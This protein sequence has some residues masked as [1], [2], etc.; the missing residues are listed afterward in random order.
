[1]QLRLFNV[2]V[3]HPELR[4]YQEF[5][6]NELRT[7]ISEGFRKFCLVLPTGGGKTVIA[8]KIIELARSLGK[9]VL[10]VAHRVELINQAGRQLERFGVVDIGIIRGEDKRTNEDAPVQ[11]ASI[12]TLRNRDYPPADIVFI[13]EC[14][15]ALSDSYRPLFNHYS[16]SLH[17]GLTA[18]PFRTDSQGLG[19]VYQKIIVCAKPSQ[20]IEDKFIMAPRIFVAPEWP[21]LSDVE[22]SGG[23]FDFH[24]NHLAKAMSKPKLLGN[25]VEEWKKHA[26]NRRTVCFAVNVE[27]SKAIVEA[28]REAGVNAVHIDGN[29]PDKERIRVL[30]ELEAMKIQLVS[31]CDVL[32][33]GWDQPSVRCAIIARPTQSLRLHLQQCGRILRWYDGDVASPE[34]TPLLIDHAGNCLRHGLPQQDREFDLVVGQHKRK[35]SVPVLHTCKQC[36]AIWMGSRKCPECGVELQAKEQDE[37]IVDETV[38]LRELREPTI[39]T[40]ADAQRAFFLKELTK[41]RDIGKR[42]GAAGYAYKEK[43][44]KWPPYSWSTQA[45][46]FYAASPDWQK[47]VEDRQKTREFWQQRKSDAESS[48][49]KYP[50]HNEEESPGNHFEDYGY[51]EIPDDDIPF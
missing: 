44:G 33:E 13:D 27:H 37:I 4:P 42:P 46:E 28:F 30:L 1:M 21:D 19:E 16:D 17:I 45:K 51:T 3:V 20:L 40:E 22:V 6:I 34:A 43:F 18:T 15:R 14:H 24:N 10:F 39:L 12:D 26:N 32:S 50:V 31:N 35:D 29:T 5:G 9:R 47:L 48:E 11:I 23:T 41:C 49:K 25:I 7:L 2:K 8:A 38:K 36:F